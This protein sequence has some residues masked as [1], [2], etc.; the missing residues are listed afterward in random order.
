MVLGE[1]KLR[2]LI[3]LSA[4]DFKPTTT[5]TRSIHENLG[6]TF[7][8]HTD[9]IEIDKRERR[10]EGGRNN[11]ICIR[12]YSMIVICNLGAENEI[13]MHTHIYI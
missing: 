3:N 13:Y 12:L 10:R 7:H 1:F 5:K 8:C 2:S 11:E 4:S 9:E 6:E